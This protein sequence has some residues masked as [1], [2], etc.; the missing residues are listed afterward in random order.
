VGKFVGWVVALQ[1]LVNV[2][3]YVAWVLGG[4]GVQLSRK[5]AKKS[6]A[7]INNIFF[8]SISLFNVLLGKGI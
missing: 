6:A 5:K 8:M 3:V 1:V 7:E 2:A 4:V